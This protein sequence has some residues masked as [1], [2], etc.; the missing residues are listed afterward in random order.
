MLLQGEAEPEPLT[1][2]KSSDKAT[3]STNLA[4]SGSLVV[5]GEAYGV[6]I[7]VRSENRQFKFNNVLFLD[8]RSHNDWSI[9]SRNFC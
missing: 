3:E 7:K 2:E 5:D 6:V 4:F 1:V 9:S 8:R